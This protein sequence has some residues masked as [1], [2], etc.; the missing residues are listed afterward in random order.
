MNVC[1]VCI[2]LTLLS[3]ACEYAFSPE[4][5]AFK[6]GAV[7]TLTLEPAYYEAL[8][9]RLEKGALY[10]LA[11]VFFIPLTRPFFTTVRSA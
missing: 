6:T 5:T 4:M 11:S 1:F 7:D 3:D 10:F 2:V 8:V 9:T